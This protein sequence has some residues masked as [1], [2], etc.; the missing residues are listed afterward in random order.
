MEFMG[1]ISTAYFAQLAICMDFLS[2]GL[3]GLDSGRAP[4]LRGWTG[5]T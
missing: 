4:K 3:D 5:W 1:L 2:L